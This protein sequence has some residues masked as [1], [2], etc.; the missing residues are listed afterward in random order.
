MFKFKKI[1]V[2]AALC[3]AAGVMMGATAAVA[4]QTVQDS[5][6]GN[7]LIINGKPCLFRG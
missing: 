5:A 3:L 6:K 1:R 4:P 2:V 7:R